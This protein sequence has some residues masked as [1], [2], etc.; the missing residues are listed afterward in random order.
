MRAARQ[1][2]HVLARRRRRRRR[3]ND[4]SELGVLA[5]RQGRAAHRASRFRA[6]G[7]GQRVEGRAL[8]LGAAA[9]A[10]LAGRAAVNAL[11]H[12]PLHLAAELRDQRLIPQLLLDRLGRA[13]ALRAETKQW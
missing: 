12:E 11:Q 10:H 2:H 4:R 6:L 5:E 1:G 9:L 7:A 8:N 3:H 13:L